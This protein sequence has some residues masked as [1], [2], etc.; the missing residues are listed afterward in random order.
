MKKY[1]GAKSYP[2]LN[3]LDN[4]LFFKI[5]GEKG[6]ETQLIG[7]LNAVLGRAG[8]PSGKEPIKSVDIQENKNFLKDILDGKSCILDVFAVLENGTKVNIEVQIRDEH[9]MDLRSLYYWS[10]TYSTSLNEG[11][12][13]NELPNVIAINIV[14]F[15]F[16][17]Q[18][19]FHTCFHL[20]EDAY[21]SII[22]T[23]AL[24]IHFINMVKWRKIRNKDIQNNSL[25]RWLTWLNDSSPPELIEE[26][27]NM[28]MTIL[29]ANEKQALLSATDQ[30]IQYY[31]LRKEMYEHDKTCMLDNARSKG[32]RIGERRG[33]KKAAFKIARNALAEGST[34]E[35]VQKIT[36]LDLDTLKKLQAKL[37]VKGLLPN[38]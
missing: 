11:Q 5:F 32:E 37:L 35:F 20:R 26:V 19:G 6:S 9:N 21:P 13:Y 15:N 33:T 8:E 34:L 17:K 38:L 10:R 24:E 1:D 23:P 16:P 14:D 30:E 27:I 28:D 36:D 4:F 31:L 2:R 25:H 29:T 12:N 7:L 3:P 22:L 18:G